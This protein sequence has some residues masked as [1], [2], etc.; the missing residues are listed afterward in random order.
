[1]FKGM[2]RNGLSSRLVNAGVNPVVAA[3]IAEVVY[4]GRGP[5]LSRPPV[6]DK[7]EAAGIVEQFVDRGTITEAEML[8]RIWGADRQDTRG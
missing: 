8:D 5:S 7:H 2:M 1:M 6:V 4:P 3:S